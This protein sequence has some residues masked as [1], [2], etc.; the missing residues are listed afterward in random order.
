MCISTARMSLMPILCCWIILQYSLQCH[1]ATT[2]VIH[3]D[4]DG[5]DTKEC[6]QLGKCGCSSLDMALDLIDPNVDNITIEI[7][8]EISLNA[9]HNVS[10]LST[11]VMTGSPTIVTCASD[12]GVTFSLINSLNLYSI[13]WI[14]CAGYPGA[15]SVYN[16]SLIATI[17]YFECCTT[18]AL[19]IIHSSA[20]FDRVFLADNKGAMY[21]SNSNLTF[22]NTSTFFHNTASVGGAI[23]FANLSHVK[24][25]S[26]TIYFFNNRADTLGG[27]IYA[28]VRSSC[29]VEP[30]LI[31]SDSNS[32]LSFFLNVAVI[33]GNSWY[34][35]VNTS[36]NF[37][38]NASNPDSLIYY[39][40]QFLYDSPSLNKQISSSLYQLKLFFPAKCIASNSKG[41]CTEYELNNVMPGQEINI[42]ATIFG[43][44]GLFGMPTEV[45]MSCSSEC[46][47]I[48]L[49]GDN[50]VTVYS[51]TAIRGFSIK[52][53]NEVADN[54]TL[55]ITTITKARPI[56]VYLTVRLSQCSSGY[57]F[58]K[59][60][61]QIYG[62]CKCYNYRD[63]VKCLNDSVAQ[64]K[65]GY[66]VGYFNDSY[67]TTTCPAQYCNFI[68]CNDCV[69]YCLLPHSHDSQCK[70]HRSG[71]AC[72]TCKSGYVLPFDSVECVENSKCSVGLILL[73]V[74][75]IIVY[76]LATTT[77]IIVLM[78]YCHFQVGYAYGIIHFYSIIDVLVAD[79]SNFAVFRF[80]TIL[81]GFAKMT[82]KFLGSLCFVDWS[83]IDQQAFHYIHPTAV[84]FMLLL[85]S[86]AARYSIR[87]SYYLRRSVILSICLIQLL[88][89]TSVA[90]A[91][92]ELLRPLRFSNIDGAFVYGSPDIG[93]F[94][95]RHIAYG[96]ITILAAI[97]FV[98]GLPLFLLLEPLCLNRYF[99]FHR[100]KPL[101]DQYQACYKNQYRHFAAYYLFCRLAILMVMYT[102][103]NY[104]NKYFILQVIC[105]TIT[106]IHGSVFP[107]KERFVN[108]LDL[109]I[110]LIITFVVSYQTGYSFTTFH[111]SQLSEVLLVGT[112]ISPLIC[113]LIFVML[114]RRKAC[115]KCWE[116]NNITFETIN[117]EDEEDGYFDMRYNNI[118]RVKH[119]LCI[120]HN[121]HARCFFFFANS[122]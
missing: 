24:F 10:G 81:S 109:I 54:I 80:I 48:M 25:V 13:I 31:E 107:Y 112:V 111:S 97:I 26:A 55:Q 3:V 46:D 117:D 118:C 95:G 7:G 75:L 115:C 93:Y 23:Y 85:L 43:Y 15:V 122:H 12:G 116:R 52:T 59:N 16:S 61:S 20:F 50:I 113:F 72:G 45:V 49:D 98:I 30:R 19:A 8:N 64:I 56:V 2:R 73:L 71:P 36:C 87:L 104:Y 69:G 18:R 76:W 17:T 33:S 74:M 91:S 89:Y 9:T 114:K 29:D 96:V 105:V 78:N 1:A 21:V 41:I 35:D 51:E 83:G 102:E 77:C 27:A 101:L 108:V 32:N 84:L 6:C 34:F 119:D 88:A 100:I 38:K 14:G 47:D 44:Y 22:V 42:P 121:W 60:N 110:L 65:Q 58:L 62:S 94:H 40:S 37:V 120:V 68:S 67:T 86:R 53:R 11:F 90:S 79:K 57:R 99:N 4:D 106:I 66:W 39:P 63:I 28:D 82:P 103:T 92:L 5:N 70:H